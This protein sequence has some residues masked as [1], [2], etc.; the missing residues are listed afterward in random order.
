MAN[1]EYCEKIKRESRD[2]INSIIFID[3]IEGFLK[4]VEELGYKSYIEFDRVINGRKVHQVNP[5]WTVV[6]FTNKL[7][8]CKNHRECCDLPMAEIT[9]DDINWLFGS[10]IELKN[11]F[12]DEIYYRYYFYE[13]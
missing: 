13:V 5:A 6:A 4:R 9:I 1:Y 12:L 3:L 2:E 7:K 11:L 10:R 8:R